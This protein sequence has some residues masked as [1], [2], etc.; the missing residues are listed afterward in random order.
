MREEQFAHNFPEWQLDEALKEA[1]NGAPTKLWQLP[2]V[3]SPDSTHSPI[4]FAQW[5]PE[6]AL[7][8]LK[9]KLPSLR[10]QRRGTASNRIDIA[11]HTGG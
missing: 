10:E 1:V 3:H 11:A 5:F 7:L 6:E 2:I 9:T 4:S 8:E